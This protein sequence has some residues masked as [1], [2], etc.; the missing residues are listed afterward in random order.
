M[1]PTQSFHVDER[2]NANLTL[3]IFNC[4]KISY[5]GQ[6]S[7]WRRSAAYDPYACGGKNV[8]GL[9]RMW[10]FPWWLDGHKVKWTMFPLSQLGVLRLL[11]VAPN[12]MS[13]RINESGE[14][15]LVFRKSSRVVVIKYRTDKPC[16]EWHGAYVYGNYLSFLHELLLGL[17]NHRCDN[18]FHDIC[19]TCLMPI[20][21]SFPWLSTIWE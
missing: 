3:C 8:T 4:K 13:A 17:W 20:I 15:I 6:V 12:L 11:Y 16:L 9:S 21:E 19:F 18:E 5:I 2:K 7:Q 1:S 14:Q 10:V